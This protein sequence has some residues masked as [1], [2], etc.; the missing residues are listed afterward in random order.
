MEKFI[1]MGTVNED[2]SITVVISEGL[3]QSLMR[4][5]LKKNPM[6]IHV[7][8]NEKHVENIKQL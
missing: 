2:G 8:L 3:R 6:V 5:N 7:C 4:R 1:K